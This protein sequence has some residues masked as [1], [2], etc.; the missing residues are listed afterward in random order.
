MCRL[1]VSQNVCDFHRRGEP[2]HEARSPHLV[3]ALGPGGGHRSP[4]RLLSGLPV[5]E[6]AECLTRA[7]A[8]R[9]SCPEIPVSLLSPPGGRGSV[10]VLSRAARVPLVLTPGCTAERL[11]ALALALARVRAALPG[12]AVSSAGGDQGTLPLPVFPLGGFTARATRPGGALASCALDPPPAPSRAPRRSPAPTPPRGVSS[13]RRAFAGD[14]SPD[15]FPDLSM[16]SLC[17]GTA[18]WQRTRSAFSKEPGASP[19]P[20][21]APLEFP[22]RGPDSVPRRLWHLFRPEPCS[23]MSGPRTPEPALDGQ[24]ASPPGSQDEDMADGTQHSH[25]MLSFSDALLSI[26]ATVMILP[27][28]HTEISPEQVFGTVCSVWCAG[29]GPGG[30]GPELEAGLRSGASRGS[31]L[32]CLFVTLACPSEQVLGEQRVAGLPGV[33]LRHEQGGAGPPAAVGE[34]P[35][36]V[37]ALLF[38]EFDK[39]VQKLLATRIAVYLMTFLIVTAAW[40]AHTRYGQAG[41]CFRAGSHTVAGWVCAQQAC[42]MTITFLPFTFSL[43]VAFPEVPLG[44]LLFC[45]CVMAVGAVQNILQRAPPET[46]L[47]PCSPPLPQALIVVYAFHFPHLLSPQIE[48]SAHRALYRQHILG[49]ILRGPALCLAA[50]G[51]SLFFY[52]VVSR[53]GGPTGGL[54]C[55]EEPAWV[56]MAHAQWA[57]EAVRLL[58][59]CLCRN[60]S[61][62]KREKAPPLQ[63][64]HEPTAIVPGALTSPFPHLGRCVGPTFQGQPLLA[65][66]ARAVLTSLWTALLPW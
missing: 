11:L 23:T 6:A 19:G 47:A 52:P 36:D 65:A 58:K 29:E 46:L 54:L 24:G 1:A 64:P 51:F 30:A 53:G 49:I 66:L 42:M 59:T 61:R 10:F 31:S 35:S 60:V 39:S 20:R 12:S 43:M 22:L 63:P 2:L 33:G 34:S 62:R 57:R 8:L 56:N 4:A 50:A 15:L 27:V 25:R 26:I 32:G 38:Q 9:S 3:C 14:S 16:P 41:A 40:A 45:V 37:D 13:S 7:S 21:P 28:T 44:I 18:P 48:R 17:P 5:A 55:R